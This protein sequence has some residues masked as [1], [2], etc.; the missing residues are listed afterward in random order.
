VYYNYRYYSPELGR[1]TKRDSIEESGGLNLYGFVGNDPVGRWDVW[2]KSDASLFQ[3]GGILTF[4]STSMGW[5]TTVTYA[6][7]FYRGWEVRCQKD[8]VI[9]ENLR[10]LSIISENILSANGIIGLDH[11]RAPFIHVTINAEVRWHP[12]N[13]GE[14]SAAACVA[15]KTTAS[16]IKTPMLAA[17][18]ALVSGS[19]AGATV[20]LTRP[21]K[22]VGFSATWSIHC[23]CK[24]SWQ[25]KNWVPVF[26][27]INSYGWEELKEEET[28]LKK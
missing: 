25:S 5:T 7:Y 15:A 12:Y 13:F 23:E 11:I 10:P 1:W 9:V 8:I 27:G 14:A 17:A 22:R 20:F 6:A 21:I 3:W 24:T 19:I 16:K 18:A 4:I 26:K 28:M 2:G